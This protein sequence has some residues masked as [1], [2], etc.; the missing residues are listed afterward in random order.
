MSTRDMIDDHLGTTVNIARRCRDNAQRRS[1]TALRAA[2]ASARH[3]I[4]TISEAVWD[5]CR[6]L[7]GC[8]FSRS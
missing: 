2:I 4:V 3:G 8:F 1:Q 5:S 6:L 7:L